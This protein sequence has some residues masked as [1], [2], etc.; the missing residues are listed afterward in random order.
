MFTTLKFSLFAL[1]HERSA[2][3]FIQKKIFSEI[4]L[5]Q[6]AT[7]V[8]GQLFG[9]YSLLNSAILVHAAFFSHLKPLLSLGVL[10]LACKCMF[11]ILQGYYH[12]TIPTSSFQ[13]PLL[14]STLALVGL[15]VLL[16]CEGDS[17]FDPEGE[18]EDLLRAMKFSK[19]K[20]RKAL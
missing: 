2:E 17:A 20:K 14:I 8:V 1:P 4:N 16:I 9:F 6:A 15:I 5:S 7:L 11:Y 12:H 13:V 19:N 18:N 10:A 3:A